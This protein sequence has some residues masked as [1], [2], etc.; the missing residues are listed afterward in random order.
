[1]FRA[2][3]LKR[4]LTETAQLGDAWSFSLKILKFR[5]FVCSGRRPSSSP[6]SVSSATSP[7]QQP[8]TRRRE[9]E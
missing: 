9:G 1:M 6:L 2:E 8:W 4:T 7:R 3:R 5:S